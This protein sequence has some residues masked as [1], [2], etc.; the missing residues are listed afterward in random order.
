[1]RNVIDSTVEDA[2]REL[3]DALR[4]RELWMSSGEP[5]VSSLTEC[6]SLLWD[7]SGLGDALE[8]GE[9]VYS[10]DID[11]QFDALSV[12]LEELDGSR[13]P[14]EILDDPALAQ[15]RGIASRLLVSLREYGYD[16]T[17]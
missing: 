5:E 6:T 9:V 4:Q 3:A 2:L 1:M 10:P 16:R 12:A 11:A 15:V 7:D 17:T 13:P 8:A 14:R